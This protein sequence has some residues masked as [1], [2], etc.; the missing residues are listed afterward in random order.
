MSS[1]QKALWLKSKQGAFEV[2]PKDIQQ[3]GP[4]ELLVKVLATA[5]NPVDWKIHAFGFLIEVFPALLG[6]DSSG[7]VEAVG[8]GVT[9]FKKGD[10]VVHPGFF[11]ND[12]ATFQQYTLV[13]ADLVAKL[14]ENISF[15]QAAS[16]P[17]GLSTA[18][19]GL[20]NNGNGAGLE[21]AWEEA[22]RGKYA[23][24]SIFI[25]GGSSSVGQYAIQLAKLSG[26]SSIIA[27]ASPAHASLL[28]SLGATHVIDRNLPAAEIAAAIMKSA[29]APVTVAYDAI[30]NADTEQIAYDALAPSGTLVLTLP[31]SFKETEGKDVSVVNVVGN[32]NLPPNKKLGV[33]LYARLTALLSEGLIKPNQVGVLPEGLAGIPS[34]LEKLKANKVSGRKLV[35]RPQETA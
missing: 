2:G 1:Q 35:V 6:T 31:K 28:T 24:K 20:Y 27:T 29:G 5:L 30:S 16:I 19:V 25:S 3:P 4:G 11:T 8:E 33:S 21:Y 26:F 9:A 7:T 22:G 34:G 17:L 12:K 10:R 13:S 14:P 32:V 18:A 23:G 15:D